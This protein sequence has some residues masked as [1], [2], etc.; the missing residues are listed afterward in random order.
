MH[1]IDCSHSVPLFE[2]V[3]IGIYCDTFINFGGQDC[4]RNNVI[5]DETNQNNYRKMQQ[6]RVHRLRESTREK[7]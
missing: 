6:E 5:D 2:V 7:Y 1:R 4:N 3:A